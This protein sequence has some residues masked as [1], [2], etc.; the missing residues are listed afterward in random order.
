MIGVDS[1]HR[2]HVKGG[3]DW[4][5]LQFLQ[6]EL[7]RARPYAERAIHRKGVDS[8]VGLNK[9]FRG[10]GWVLNRG[11]QQAACDFYNQ[12]LEAARVLDIE[13]P[14]THLGAHL[15]A[16]LDWFGNPGKYAA[17]VDEGWNRTLKGCARGL[18]QTTFDVCLLSAVN[19]KLADHHRRSVPVVP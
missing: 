12:Y 15:I 16:E 2:L 1:D 18:S 3:E 9:L 11:E 19:E 14:K 7:R 8:L 10:C 4:S 5:V 6:A 13:L 17:W